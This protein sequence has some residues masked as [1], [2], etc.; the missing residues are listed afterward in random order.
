[1]ALDKKEDK[2]QLDLYK[3]LAYRKEVF[4]D[5]TPVAKFGAYLTA[6]VGVGYTLFKI[7]YGNKLDH[8]FQNYPEYCWSSG[9]M[10]LMALLAYVSIIV[11]EFRINKADAVILKELIGIRIEEIHNSNHSAPR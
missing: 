6:I 8:L 9:I 3:V 1:M 10:M 5:F 4:A 2:A 11:S 7:I